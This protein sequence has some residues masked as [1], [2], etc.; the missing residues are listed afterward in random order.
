MKLLLNDRNLIENIGSA[1]EYGA[2]GNVED[3]KS[4]RITPTSYRMDENFTLVD[5]GDIE[6]PTYV[7]EGQYYYIDGEFRLADECPNEYK[8]KIVV[9]EDEIAATQDA[10]CEQSETTE[11]SISDIENAM[12][13]TETITDERISA[14]EDALCEKSAILEAL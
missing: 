5:I 11:T 6:I 12:C 14:L 3:M 2:W 4:W 7:K 10:I 1:I 13:E 8:D 9:L